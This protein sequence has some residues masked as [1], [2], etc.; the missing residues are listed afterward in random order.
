LSILAQILT[1]HSITVSQD[2]RRCHM[3]FPLF[4]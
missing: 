1:P 4:A 2:D 3:H